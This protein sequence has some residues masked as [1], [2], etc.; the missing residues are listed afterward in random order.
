LDEGW[1]Y[2][3]EYSH[4]FKN[5]GVVFGDQ[6]VKKLRK[7]EDWEEEWVE[8]DQKDWVYLDEPIEE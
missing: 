4:D 6:L 3:D 7:G 1:V 5:E 2:E 8:L